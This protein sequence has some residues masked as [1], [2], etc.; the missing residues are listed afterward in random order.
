MPKVKTEKKT[1]VH[2]QI[3][4]G[5]HFKKEYGQHI[6]KNPLVI[7]GIVDKVSWQN[8]DAG[9]AYVKSS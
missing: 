9:F 4:Q 3:Q 6:L 8:S 7:Q 5:I 2:G 1:R